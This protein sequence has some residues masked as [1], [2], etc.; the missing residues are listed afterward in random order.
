MLK[1]TPSSTNKKLR[2]PT[3]IPAKVDFTDDKI[4]RDKRQMLPNKQMINPQGKTQ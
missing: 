2:I 4:T 1:D 3:L